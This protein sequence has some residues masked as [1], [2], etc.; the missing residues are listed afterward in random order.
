MNEL[1]QVDK[2]TLYGTRL[3]VFLEEGPQSNQY[4]HVHLNPQ[5]LK[6]VSDAICTVVD[7]QGD[8]ENVTVEMSV[9]TYK[10]P[11]L[12]EINLK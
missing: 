2:Y 9:E 10:L 12:Q 1:N 7:R 8:E 6:M 3:L 11:D 5:Q 4:H